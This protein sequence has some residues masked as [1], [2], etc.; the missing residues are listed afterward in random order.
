MATIWHPST[1]IFPFRHG[2]PSWSVRGQMGNVR[3]QDPTPNQLLRALELLDLTIVDDGWRGR[4]QE[5]TRACEVLCEAMQ[6]GTQYPSDL[7][8]LDR[9]FSHFAVAAR[10]GR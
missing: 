4:R 3:V 8:S 7:P 10:A 9:Y 1:V 2:S 5:L 6:G